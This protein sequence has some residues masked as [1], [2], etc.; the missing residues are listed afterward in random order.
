MISGAGGAFE[1]FLPPA[2]AKEMMTDP[3]VVVGG[4]F[5][6]TGRAVEVEGG[7]RIS[8][9]WGVASGCQHCDWLGGSCFVFDGPGPRMTQFGPEWVVPMMPASACRV[10]DTWDV[11]GLRG[12]GSHDFE[13]NDLFVPTQR[14]IRIPMGE[15]PYAGRLFAFP[16][17][18]LL[19]SA[20]ASV[21]LGIARAALDDL[22]RVAKTKTP[23][24]MMSTLATRPSAQIAYCEAEAE[25][26]S[27]R[28]LLFDSVASTWARVQA[29]EAISPTD[30]AFLRLAATN[31]TSRAASA[32][33]RAYTAGGG[34]A[35][36]TR[37]PLQRC[38]RDVHMITQHAIVAPHVYE[39]TG[40]ILLGAEPDAPML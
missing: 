8:G 39:L 1:G 25:L 26:R 18:G 37:S 38:L 34:S 32:V 19:G 20:I 5:A 4:V 2:G 7:Y 31:A 17:F 33:D 28:A 9:K 30:R 13:V 10:L 11:S 6:P 14:V 15:S 3:G 35:V 40:K 29:K 21:A 27:A 36:Y 12:T 24:G 16:F 22:A 23:F